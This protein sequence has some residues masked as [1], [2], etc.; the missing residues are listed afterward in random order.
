MRGGYRISVNQQ[1]VNQHIRDLM[2]AMLDGRIDEDTAGAMLDE[3]ALN[4]TH[5]GGTET[6]RNL[7]VGRSG[8]WMIW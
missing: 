7:L 6:R 8:E 5:H 2:Q 4:N 3:I 1:I